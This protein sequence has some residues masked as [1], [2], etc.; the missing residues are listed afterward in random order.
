MSDARPDPSA[1]NPR[2]PFEMLVGQA[3]TR[4]GYPVRHWIFP[5]NTGDVSTV[6]QGRR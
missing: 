6:E 4:D 2:I 5:G 3:V 1:A